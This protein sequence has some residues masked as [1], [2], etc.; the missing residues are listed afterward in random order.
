MIH[1]K[2]HPHTYEAIESII[3]SDA[4]PY[5]TKQSFGEAA[6]EYFLQFIQQEDIKAS[7]QLL[8]EAAIQHFRQISRK[9]PR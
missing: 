9:L 7:S 1:V 3:A 2:V 6:L 8:T 5:G 4:Y